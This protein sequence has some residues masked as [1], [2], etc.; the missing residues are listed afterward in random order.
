MD[1]HDVCFQILFLDNL[2]LQIL[3]MLFF[4]L[5]K[6]ELAMLQAQPFHALF[7]RVSCNI[8]LESL[9]HT[10]QPWIGFVFG[11]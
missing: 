8:F 5:D 4:F 11:A 2:L 3:Q 9:K 7:A 6:P 1:I 10:D